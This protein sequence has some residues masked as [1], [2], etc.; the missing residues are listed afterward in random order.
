MKFASTALILGTAAFLG[1]A[2]VGCSAS[3]NTD[4]H[5]HDDATVTK[6]SSVTVDRDGD[7]VKKTETR[8]TTN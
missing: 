4:G 3:L 6:K 7:T 1:T 8:T 2:I 5:A